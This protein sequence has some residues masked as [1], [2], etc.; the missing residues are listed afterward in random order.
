MKILVVG[1]VSIALLVIVVSLVGAVISRSTIQGQ[2]ILTERW[3]DGQKIVTFV[4]DDHIWIRSG[5]STLV[6][7]PD[8][9]SHDKE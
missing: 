2:P 9:P 8:C 3:V 5:S 7:H 6:H 1:F 4:L